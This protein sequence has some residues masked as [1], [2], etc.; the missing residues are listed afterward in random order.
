MKK[1]PPIAVSQALR[2]TNSAL[3]ARSRAVWSM[4]LGIFRT[5]GLY[6]PLAWAGALTLGYGGIVAAAA[7]ANVAIVFA[8][9]W[10]ANRNALWPGLW[11]DGMGDLGAKPSHAG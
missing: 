6:L 7:A 10:A 3:N 8:A 2:V 9:I 5:F 4:G 11:L 1:P